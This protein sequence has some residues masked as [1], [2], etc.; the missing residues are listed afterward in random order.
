MVLSVLFAIVWALAHGSQVAMAESH[1]SMNDVKGNPVLNDFDLKTTG[2]KWSSGEYHTLSSLTSS[3]QQNQQHDDHYP[4]VVDDNQS[5]EEPK[6]DVVHLELTTDMP[7][8]L[9]RSKYVKS[10]AGYLY[11]GGRSTEYYQDSVIDDQR[12]EYSTSIVNV[13]PKWNKYVILSMKC[14]NEV[15]LY[16]HPYGLNIL[17][18]C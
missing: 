1:R 8:F 11:N 15:S 7:P 18:N 17:S 10:P 2:Q 14:L 16:V 13:V 4:L 9:M 5:A 3:S 12:P 6:M